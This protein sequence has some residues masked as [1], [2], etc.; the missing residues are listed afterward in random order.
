MSQ[1]SLLDDVLQCYAN[2]PVENATLYDAVA[3]K[4]R[5]DLNQQVKPA[6]KQEAVNVYKRKLRWLQQDLKQAGLIENLGK[7]HWRLTR[8]GRHTLTQTIADKYLVAGSTSLGIFVW[9]NSELSQLGALNEP[10]HLCF[11]SPPYPGIERSYGNYHDEDRYIDFMI[12]VVAAVRKHMVPGANLALNI[13]NDSVI[14]KAFGERSMYLEK[15]TLRLC[16]ELDLY[17]MDRLVWEAPD[18]GT[19][20]YHVTHAR[21]HLAS[22]YEPI[23]WFCTDPKHCLADN[24]RV[25]KPYSKSMEYILKQGGVQH[26]RK[27]TDYQPN[28]RKGGFSVDHGG[29]IPGNVLRFNVKC[30]ENMKI[31]AQARQ[32]GLP[33][34]GA[35]FP[36]AL[37]EFVVKW[38]CPEDGRVVEPFAGYGNVPLAAENT[39]RKWWACEWHWEYLKPAIARMSDRQ[40]FWLNPLFDQLSDQTLRYTLSS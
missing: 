25:L 1:L 23:L 19:K 5:V 11:T 17:L 18:K 12:R 40:G 35:L 31:L 6:G 14:K 38:L 2:G 16:S 3:K 30:Q 39:G 24:R 8:E 32:M 29:A 4:H 7:G 15:L 22:R 28:S 34:H 9:C 21:T 20:G 13:T 37:A 27:P 33:P 10:V 26:D 36:Y